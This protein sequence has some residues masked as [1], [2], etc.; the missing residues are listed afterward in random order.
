VPIYK[1]GKQTKPIDLDVFKKAIEEPVERFRKKSHKSF[2]VFLY[3]FG[4]RRSEALERMPEDFE[5]KDGLLIVNAPAKK[6]GEREPLE[7][8]VNYPY[9]HLIIERLNKTK[10]NQRLWPFS[11]VTAWKVV[12]RAMGKKYYPHFFR[13]N[14]ATRFLDDSSTTLPQMKAWFG[15]RRSATVDAYI[16]YSRRHVKE[17]R[18]K[19]SQELK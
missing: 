13:L 17:M 14:R 6:G 2:L 9:V 12:K 4:V 3:W 11:S 19:L 10:P 5:V 18:A 16:G 1:Y 15:W 7:V 8:P